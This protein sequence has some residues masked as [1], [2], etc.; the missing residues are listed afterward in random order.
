M[1]KYFV[2]LSILVLLWYFQKANCCGLDQ[3]DLL[4]TA[5]SS[6]LGWLPANMT[7][8]TLLKGRDVPGLRPIADADLIPSWTNFTLL[9]VGQEFAQKNSGYLGMSHL[10][11][12]IFDNF[13][14]DVKDILLTTG[15]SNIKERAARRY[16]ATAVQVL[17]WYQN[18]FHIPDER[19]I[20]IQS[21]QKVR[22]IHFD[23]AF[24]VQQK[25]KD[26]NF[27]EAQRSEMKSQ[28]EARKP[29]IYN[30]YPFWFAFHEDLKNSYIP[31]DKREYPQWK[32]NGIPI[33][34]FTQ[35]LTQFSFAGMVVLYHKQLGIV[36]VTDE[37]IRG[38]VH[39]WGVL[40]HM[41]GIHDEFNICL[42]ADLQR[43]KELFEEMTEKIFIPALFQMDESSHIQ[44]S[45]Y[46]DGLQYMNEMLTPRLMVY[47]FLRDIVQIQ[48]TF[49]YK[50]MP[51]IDKMYVAG[52]DGLITDNS[53]TNRW[54]V[55]RNGQ[56][57]LD[58]NGYR[59]FRGNYHSE[60]HKSRG[61]FYTREKLV[62]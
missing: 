19:R 34:Q 50:T 57:F 48:P 1:A 4:P 24:K 60:D 20:L 41:L 46:L 21:V 18:S 61:A 45:G 2:H 27:L 59:F 12:L 47:R 23:A 11:A 56:F 3:N 31:D 7:V 37:E 62:L 38:F 40:G 52:L 29:S 26:K 53:M 16:T 25:L 30:D 58:S 35:G 9:R 36:H 10:F 14:P 17:L 33:T 44:L 5:N 8:A 54:L 55:N 39:L 42:Q 28:M 6:C 43:T 22:Q 32:Y 51:A 15:S 13:L 49:M